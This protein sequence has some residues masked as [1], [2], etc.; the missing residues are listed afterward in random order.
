MRCNNCGWPNKPGERVCAKCHAPLE[1]PPS[2]SPAGQSYE[3]AASPAGNLKKTVSESAAFGGG[4]YQPQPQQPQAETTQQCPKCGYPLRPGTE[5]CP[6]CKYVFF[7]EAYNQAMPVDEFASRRKTRLAN[8]PGTV[9]N[10]FKGTVI[11]PYLMMNLEDDL[12]CFLRPVKRINERHELP[13]VELEGSEIVL[14]RA[15][16]DPNNSSITSKEQ[17]LLTREG[18]NWYIEDRS[19][20]KTTF[21][22]A[23]RKIELQDGDIILLGNRLFE[24]HK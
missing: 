16:T 12:Y 17:A 13:E 21:V 10:K 8:E 11:N 5:K 14:N 6:N 20:Q 7:P 18:G 15:N 19:E 24:F 22:R 4:G 1:A 3:P 23:A 9:N 2:T